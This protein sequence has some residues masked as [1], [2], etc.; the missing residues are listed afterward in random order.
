MSQY[1]NNHFTMHQIFMNHDNFQAHAHRKNYA[2][3]FELNSNTQNPQFPPKF[4]SAAL[5]P[6]Y[7][8]LHLALTSYSCT[9]PLNRQRKVKTLLQPLEKIEK[10]FQSIKHKFFKKIF[11]FGS[12]SASF[13]WWWALGSDSNL[14]D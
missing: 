8:A 14:L 2:A 7:R 6:Q 3:Q 11:S 5:I 13:F 1:S 9:K 10:Y 4:K 12:F